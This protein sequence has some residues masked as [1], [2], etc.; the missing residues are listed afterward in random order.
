MKL[1]VEIPD[2]KL[3]FALE[4]FKNI[5]FVKKVQS[6]DSEEMSNSAEKSLLI[7]ELKESI[8][9]LNLVKQGKLKAKPAR[10]LLYEL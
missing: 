5:S 8:H 3:A 7:E 6:I 1:L 10:E 2:N 9:N 4:F